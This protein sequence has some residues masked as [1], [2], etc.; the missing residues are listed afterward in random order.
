[1]WSKMTQFDQMLLS[2]RLLFSNKYITMLI[3]SFNFIEVDALLWDNLR[4]EKNGENANI[5]VEEF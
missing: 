2:S 5:I 4:Q 3:N 1:M